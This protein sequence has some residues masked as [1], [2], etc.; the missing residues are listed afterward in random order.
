M[1]NKRKISTILGVCAATVVAAGGSAYLTNTG[2]SLLNTNW[3]TAFQ[4]EDER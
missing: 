1:S 3:Q 2:L 4:P